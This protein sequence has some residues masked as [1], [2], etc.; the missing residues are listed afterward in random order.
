MHIKGITIML[1]IVNITLTRIDVVKN[2]LNW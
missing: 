2:V 1:L